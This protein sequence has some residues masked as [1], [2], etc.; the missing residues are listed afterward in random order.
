MARLE[1]IKRWQLRQTNIVN[2]INH[3]I[4]SMHGFRT[5]ESRF[6]SIGVTICKKINNKQ[7]SLEKALND[8]IDF[9]RDRGLR[10]NEIRMAWSSLHLA[11]GLC[12]QYNVKNK[13]TLRRFLD[14]RDNS[15]RIA[16][17]YLFYN[18]FFHWLMF[19]VKSTTNMPLGV[20]SANEPP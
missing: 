4:G 15:Q 20:L 18:M 14:V 3:K 6:E 11:L 19:T 10:R 1:K 7:I 9:S 13:E 12:F 16:F 17:Y 2:V 8:I 5:L